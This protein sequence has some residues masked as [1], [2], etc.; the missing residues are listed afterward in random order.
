MAGAPVVLVARSAQVLV[1][2]P[3]PV[4][5]LAPEVK[6]RWERLRVPQDHVDFLAARWLAQAAVAQLTGVARVRFVQRCDGCGSSAHGAPSVEGIDVGVSWAHAGGVVAAAAAHGPVGVDVETKVGA[7]EPVD[8]SSSVT[9]RAFVRAEALV[10]LGHFDLD[11]GL[12]AN[13]D[14]PWGSTRDVDGVTVR[15]LDPP[16]GIGAVAFPA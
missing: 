11:T 5:I 12:A 6:Q 16:E 2:V 10:K 8:P 14:W 3:D 4:S 13:L 7:D 1:D 15:D 9:G